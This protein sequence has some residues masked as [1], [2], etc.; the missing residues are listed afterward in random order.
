MA[1]RSK[2]TLLSVFFALLVVGVALL[3]MKVDDQIAALSALAT[4]VEGSQ[5]ALSTDLRES[6]LALVQSA[7]AAQSWTLLLGF[8]LLLCGLGSAAVLLRTPAG[9]RGSEA[10]ADLAA[11]DSRSKE[12]SEGSSTEAHYKQLFDDLPLP[13]LE[14]GWER[15]KRLLDEMVAGGVDDLQAY[16]LDHPSKLGE[17]YNAA[18]RYGASHA[19]L[20]LYNAKTREEFMA[21][22]ENARGGRNRDQLLQRAHFR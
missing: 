7:G 13:I 12:A 17:L 4:T 8:G 11:A 6:I 15:V 5:Q 3:W 9:S 1:N 21:T 16:L 19:A 2:I 20:R 10:A 18:D 22:M 14:E